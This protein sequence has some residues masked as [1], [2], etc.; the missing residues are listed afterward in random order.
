[1]YLANRERLLK[2]LLETCP[3]REVRFLAGQ[4][5]LPYSLY[6]ELTR[7]NMPYAVATKRALFLSTSKTMS[8]VLRKKK[9]RTDILYEALG[10]HVPW[11]DEGYVLPEFTVDAFARIEPGKPPSPYDASPTD[12]GTYIHEKYGELIGA[13]CGELLEIDGADVVIPGRI[14]HPR[15]APVGITPDALGVLRSGSA[16]A[17]GYMEKVHRGGIIQE[18]GE[19]SPLFTMELKTIQTAAGTISDREYEDALSRPD[20]DTVL[21]EL[22]VP[23]LEAAG[24][25]KPGVFSGTTPDDKCDGLRKRRGGSSFFTKSTKL[26]PTKGYRR[27]IAIGK[28]SAD[29]LPACARSGSSVNLADV[30]VP[31]R[32]RL[33]MM[34][35]DGI[36]RDWSWNESPL[37]VGPASEVFAQILAQNAVLSEYAGEGVRS[38]FAVA[39]KRHCCGQN[40]FIEQIPTRLRFVLLL[41]VK[42]GPVIRANFNA[43][44]TRHLELALQRKSENLKK[45]AT[46]V[47]ATDAAAPSSSD[48]SRKR[49]AENLDN[50]WE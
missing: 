39:F 47:S 38:V 8:A 27:N 50:V 25:M 5:D 29:V 40:Q 11:W 23:K 13:W 49:K 12:C 43:E 2:R 10:A 19:G 41:E 14:L 30:V 28:V 18:E 15:I 3:D 33:V 26:Y 46:A 44:L 37:V 6:Y 42:I 21:G 16:F 22:L 20:G 48:I 36:L 32:A 17:R 24:W 35:D 45:A 9:G 4:T 7:K 34:S 31:S 1:M